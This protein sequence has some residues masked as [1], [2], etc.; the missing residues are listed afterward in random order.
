MIPRKD[1]EENFYNYLKRVRP[2][3]RLVS[4]FKEEFM[5]AYEERKRDIKGEYL[6]KD[7][8]V[9]MLEADL[10]KLVEMGLRGSI[11]ESQVSKRSKELEQQITLAKMA[12]EECFDE[13]LEIESVLNY[14][15][16]FIQTPHIAWLDASPQAKMKYQRMIFPQ[17]VFFEKKEL[18]NPEISLSFKLISEMEAAKTT[19]VSQVG[20][21]PTTFCLK[22][23]G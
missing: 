7:E 23:G 4:L 5:K 8:E 1:I 19:I 21:E 17:G 18:S 15:L 22:G 13:E 16:A 3:E 20:F 12:R 6:R 2:T 10:D 14:C 11:P 9:R